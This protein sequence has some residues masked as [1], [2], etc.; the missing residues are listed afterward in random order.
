MGT[1]VNLRDFFRHYRG[2][3]H[4]AAAVELL[5]QQMPES[6]LRADADWV[7][8]YRSAPPPKPSPPPAPSSNGILLNVPYYSQR[9]S[10]VP[11]QAPRS[12]FSSSCA[13]LVNYLRPGALGAGGNADDVYLRR[14][15]QY[16][17]TTSAGA[18]LRA[19]QHFG[20]KA[21]FRQNCGWSDIEHQLKRG[22][23]VPVGVLHHG[24]VSSPSGG[25]HWLTVV[26]MAPGSWVCNDPWGEMDLVNGTYPSTKGKGVAYSRKNLGPR[27]MAEGEG[28]GWAIIADP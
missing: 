1:H 24:P 18:Q 2:E 7:V 17:D 10:A 28:T 23:P 14:V 11:G 21:E 27:W 22:V 26:G 3:P 25:G 20:I 4:Q 13:M 19:L 5:A 8:A 16:G 12:C 15:L 9:D 6:L